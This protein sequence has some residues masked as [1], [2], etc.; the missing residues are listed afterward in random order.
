ML[1]VGNKYKTKE[2]YNLT[3]ASS[4]V[5]TPY[6]EDEITVVVEE[7][8]L[9]GDYCLT[10]LDNGRR[11]IN[12]GSGEFFYANDRLIK[13]RSAEFTEVKVEPEY[14]YEYQWVIYLENI[15]EYVFSDYV[16]SREE[17]DISPTAK[18]I[19][20]FEKSKRIRK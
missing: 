12:E 6:T 16:A 9:D 17:L 19:E 14:E 13:A 15:K 2:F 4:L 20:R 3:Y 1:K 11:I 18:V 10:I 5:G 7:I 8:D